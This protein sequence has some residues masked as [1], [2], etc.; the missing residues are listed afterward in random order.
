MVAPRPIRAVLWDADGVLQEVP[1][2]WRAL[3]TDAIGAERTH[4][5]LTDVWPSAREAMSG[6]GDLVTELGRLLEEHGLTGS[7]DRVR[8]VWGT[9]DRF[10][11]S[12]ALVGEVRDLGVGCHLA[13]NQDPLRAA[14]MRERLA[15][16]DLMDSCYYSC[17][18]GTAKPEADFFARIAAD[19]ELAF[20]EL[21]FVDDL[22]ENVET[23]RGLGVHAIHW[24]HRD[25]VAVLR[26]HLSSL[27]LALG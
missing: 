13:T 9:F 26:E 15:Y 14:Y 22:A 25:G 27:G 2:G 3:L 7:A 1:G 24:H 8:E 23:A 20:D 17:D 5:L 4:A 19:L 18:L 16:D 11:D 12:R 6:R 10:D 21:A